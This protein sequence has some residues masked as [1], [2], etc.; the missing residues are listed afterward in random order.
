MAARRDYQPRSASS[1]RLGNKI[2]RL[3]RIGCLP[4]A[5]FMHRTER[6]G[7]RKNIRLKRMP[8][9][10]RNQSSMIMSRPIRSTVVVAALIAA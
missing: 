3:F 7:R 8:S 10:G 5:L 2:Y 9:D 6:V 4:A 1:L